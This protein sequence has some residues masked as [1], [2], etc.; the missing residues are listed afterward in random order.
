MNAS[1]VALW[2]VT[3]AVLAVGGCSESRTCHQGDFTSCTCDDGKAG[4]AACDVA[5]DDYGACGYCGSIP[6]SSVAVG[7]GGAGGGTA[8][9]GA[10]AGGAEPLGFMETCK[11]DEDCAS[12]QCHTYNAKG[13]KCTI[14]CQTDSD[15]PAPSPGCN[16]MGVCKAP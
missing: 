5:S 7:V 2:L 15:C 14:S 1:G 8:T 4:F 10:G 16:N 6:G 13:Q 11:K 9:G 3:A 12:G